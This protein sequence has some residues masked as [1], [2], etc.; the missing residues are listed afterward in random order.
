MN[1][2]LFFFLTLTTLNC[3]GQVTISGRLLNQADTK[4]LPNASVFLNNTSA[5][6]KTAADGTFVLH[7]V[8][9][10]KYELIVSIIGFE[11]YTQPIQ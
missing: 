6:N 5:G 10:G 3:L 1:N 7:N 11:T 8:K 9:P 4:P 2:F